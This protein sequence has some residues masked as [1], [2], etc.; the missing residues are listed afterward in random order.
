MRKLLEMRGITKI[1]PGVVANDHVDFEVA[2]GEI[3][4]LLG[5]NGA[6]KTTLMNILYGLYVPDSGEIFI[7]GERADIHSPHDAIALSIG[8]VHQEFMLVPTFTVAENVGLGLDPTRSPF[9]ELGSVETRIKEFSS[10]HGLTV[11]PSVKVKHLS[12]GVQ[13]RVE[14]VKL[15]YRDARLLILDEPTA[16][17]TPQEAEAL[18]AVLRSLVR[19]GRSVIFITHKLN[20][21]MAVSDRVT[22]L[23]D[24]K[25][26]AT[27]KTKD[28]NPRE[29]AE[30]MVGR[31]APFR[32]DR[33]PLTPGTTVLKVEDVHAVDDRGVLALRGIS[34]QV[35]EREI[36]GLAGVDG[37]GQCELAEVL[38]GLRPASKGKVILTGHDVT[39]APPSQR[40]S[41]GMAY[42]PAERRA[43]GCVESLDVACNCILGRPSDFTTAKGWLLA[44]SELRRYAEELVSDFDV[45]TPS[46]EV[47]AAKLSGGNLQ[48]L[49]LGRELMRDPKLLVAEQPTRGLD[50]GATEY[51]RSKIL[52]ARRD[53][54]AILL[55]SSELE[56]ILALSD[57]ISVIYEGE[58]VGTVRAE[59]ADLQLIGLMM[60]GS[61]RDS[62]VSTRIES[63][64]LG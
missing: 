18:F 38:A 60:A 23:R 12:V 40:Y 52:E 37:N 20:E 24:G 44:R 48:K 28:T 26:I 43:V 56:E 19:E 13:Q 4:A 39:N 36:L 8:M 15:L 59:E 58:I 10:R 30:M 9:L 16:V 33:Q 57:R 51:V 32:T 41:R 63:T 47:L 22:V 34:L 50:V 21:V 55:V 1:F 45:R 61:H 14:I 31:E 35:R 64:T 53:G 5:E 42:V 7:R 54:A 29:L 49:L 17:L 6:G 2:E 46:T 3:H 11:D 25:V 62:S 27:K